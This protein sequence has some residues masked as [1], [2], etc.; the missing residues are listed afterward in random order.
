[1]S[2]M[3]D[4][5]KLPR[6]QKILVFVLIGGLI[7]ALYYQLRFKSLKSHLAQAEA[8][9]QN[10]INQNKRLDAEIPKFEE[11][12]TQMTRLKR[13]IDENQKA[14][15][16]EAELPAFFDLL[17]RKVTES[18]VQITSSRRLKEEPVEKFVKVPVEVEM[19]GTFMQIKKFFASLLP[20]KHKPGEQVADG[21]NVEEKERLVSVENLSLTD[22]VVKNHEIVLT[23]KFTMVTYR[24]DEPEAASGAPKSATP[25]KPV[26]KTL[27]PADTPA[28]AKARV[29]QSL[30]KGDQRNRNATGVDEAK[31]PAGSAGRLKGGL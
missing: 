24:Q 31:T 17:N 27:P 20:K 10:Q 28:G 8:A 15:P 25:Q 16:T 18:G 4:F 13:V 29:E 26:Q 9:H 12:K 5:A 30:D 22:P 3:Q 14:L 19:T 21:D 11:L 23:A 6:Q 7:G 2:A 1:M